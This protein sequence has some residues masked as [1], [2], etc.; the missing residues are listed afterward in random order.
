MAPPQRRRTGCW[1]CRL[2]RKKCSEGGPP[3]ETCVTRQVHCHGYGPK[4]AWKDK[5]EKERQE[6]IRL[7]LVAPGTRRAATAASDQSPCCFDDVANNQPATPASPFDLEADQTSDALSSLSSGNEGLGNLVTPTSEIG[8]V[9]SAD[10]DLA[11]SEDHWES[12]D[13]T[14]G[15]SSIF[16]DLPMLADQVD[17]DT[18]PDH[19]QR[20]DHSSSE[21]ETDLIMNYIS[22]TCAKVSE[23][24]K[25]Q[26]YATPR[27]WLL[28]VLLNS[29]GFYSATLSLSAYEEY[30]EPAIGNDWRASAYQDYRHHRSRAAHLFSNSPMVAFQGEGLVCAVQLA[31]LE[32]L[33]GNSQ[34]CQDYLQSSLRYLRELEDSE[35]SNQNTFPVQHDGLPSPLSPVIGSTYTAS[36]IREHQS[37][38]LFSSDEKIIAFS[39][40]LL[41]WMDILTCTIRGVVPSSLDSYNCLL[42]NHELQGNFQTAT[43]CEAWV[44]QAIMAL[45]ALGAWKDEQ[46]SRNEL[47]IRT[48]VKRAD[49]ISTTIED[50]IR[51][52]PVPDSSGT[53]TMTVLYAH[54]ALVYL[55]MVV[56]GSNS[57][58]AETTQCIEGAIEAWKRLPPAI[59]QQ[60]P[61]WP[62]LITAV[63]ARGEQR[64]FFRGLL[65]AS[66]LDSRVGTP[67]G[68]V[69]SAIER[70]WSEDEEA[71]NGCDWKGILAQQ[72]VGVLIS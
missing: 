66:S 60:P 31:W 36:A 12:F 57:A 27:G 48:L 68:N 64:Q 35:R 19:G 38:G 62:L 40:S 54:A 22:R 42:S 59:Q 20:L 43:G 24:N 49:A 34:Q 39:K 69:R 67:H 21:R 9:T 53:Q 1:T 23:G 50:G 55:N 10:M 71:I 14:A 7:R 45:S 56:S 11:L 58:I 15:L 6:A 8:Q 61:T 18:R 2:R 37:N 47:S 29:P 63:L 70:C 33:G 52:L 30:L 28:R 72:Q 5:G 51:R 26:Q 46:E 65:A 13:S 4:P 3:C 17:N 25:G 41:A 16:I 44:L 32:A